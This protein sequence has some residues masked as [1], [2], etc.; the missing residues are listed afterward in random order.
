MTKEATKTKF[1]FVTGGVVSSLG[2][3]VALMA[4]MHAANRYDR[5]TDGVESVL[6]RP[7][8]SLAATVRANRDLFQAPKVTPAR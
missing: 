5:I 1:I 6:G 4:E 2:K 8:T 3:G 7:P